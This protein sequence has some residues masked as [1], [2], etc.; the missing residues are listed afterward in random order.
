MIGAGAVVTKNVQNYSL[1]VGN[2]A[3]HVG[4]VSQHG[5]K[6]KFDKSGFAICNESK[7]KY[8]LSKNNVER[9]Y[10]SS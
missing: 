3:R 7:E 9:V 4:W 2:P 8:F 5:N 1:V 10:E 6:L